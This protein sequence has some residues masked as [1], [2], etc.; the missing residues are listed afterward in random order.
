MIEREVVCTETDMRLFA[1]GSGDVSPLHTDPDFARFTPYGACI[2]YGGILSLALL[3]TLPP[4][5]LA[6]MRTVRSSFPGPVLPD[7]PLVARAT[8][9]PRR[10]GTWE[11]KLLEG[12]RQLARLVAS[13]DPDGHAAA[14]L[15][16]ALGGPYT[17]GDELHTLADR[18]G[19]G[20]LDPALREGI[21][22]ASYL[23]GMAMPGFDGLCA[24]VDLTAEGTGSGSA[25][26][27]HALV[28]DHD[29]RT[30]RRLIEGVLLDES[31]EV[32][33][34]ARIECFPIPILEL[35]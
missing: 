9:H 23:V 35:G 25:V 13:A 14:D 1:S 12:D 19:A 33:T 22:W 32:R 20:Q 30:E 17:A 2:V 31:G 10:P 6:R 16:G 27:G 18:L 26:R 29:P 21:G 8:E 7:V 34:T 4:D 15:D 3:G 28:R 24:A 11:V 5:A